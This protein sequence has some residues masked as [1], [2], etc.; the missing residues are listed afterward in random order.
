MITSGVIEHLMTQ[1]RDNNRVGVAYI[2]CNYRK[3]N[4]QDDETLFSSLLKQLCQGQTPLPTCLRDL[5]SSHEQYDTRPTVEELIETL[6]PVVEAYDRIF[7]IV[8]ALDECK[9]ASTV[10]R[11]LMTGLLHL[12]AKCGANLFATS[13]FI[14]GI[15]CIFRHS[16]TLEVQATSADM[17]RFLRSEI[18]GLPYVGRQTEQLQ[19]EIC[20]SIADAAGGMYVHIVSV[21]T[22]RD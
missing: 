8:D 16:P 14:P 19:Q 2:F 3:Q 21:W 4:Q 20:S 5:Y 12:Q 6:Q 11:A 13:R 18:H 1:F 7:L 15:T 9:Y 22:Y 10:P 17:I